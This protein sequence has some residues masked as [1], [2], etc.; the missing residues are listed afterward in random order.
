MKKQDLPFMEHI[1]D[2]ISD[3]ER[4]TEGLSKQQFAGNKDVRDANIRRIE[5]IGEAVKNISKEL[6]ERN[7]NIEWSKIAGTRDKIIHKYFGIDIEL[8]WNI[9]KKD[10]PDF[11]KK[12]ES[13]KKDL[14]L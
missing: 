8:I 2:A 1:L 6:K 13:I 12:I 7:K 4:S 14:E 3:I 10:I 11:K 5:V 9:I